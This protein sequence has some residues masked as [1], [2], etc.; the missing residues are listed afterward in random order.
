LSPSEL[1]VAE[2]KLENANTNENTNDIDNNNDSSENDTYLASIHFPAH[3][4]E[5]CPSIQN[6]FMYTC[7]PTINAKRWKPYLAYRPIKVVRR[8]LKQTA[9]MAKLSTSIS[10]RRHVQ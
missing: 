7:A 3:L 4:L 5:N 1:H 8:T 2:N 6:C 9:Q 10:M